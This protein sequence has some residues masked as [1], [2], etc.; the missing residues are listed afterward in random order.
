MHDVPLV[1][2]GFE[3]SRT[4]YDFAAAQMAWGSLPIWQLA[5]GTA[6][7]VAASRQQAR[8]AGTLAS[9]SSRTGHRAI[10]ITRIASAGQVADR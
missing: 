9:L 3:N 10:T 5:G 8:N 1:L 2:D 7:L 6:R 4:F